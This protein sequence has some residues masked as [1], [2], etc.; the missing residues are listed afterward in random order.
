MSY[1]LLLADD[2]SAFRE[3]VREVCTPFFEILE[4]DTGDAAWEIAIVAQPDLALCDFHM[5]G[6]TGLE[7][8]S[9][10]K[11]IDVRRPAILMSSELSPDLEQLA[12]RAHIDSLLQKPFSRRILL[13]TF[14]A[15]METAYHDQSF[16]QRLLSS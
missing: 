3:I 9:A 5:P 1:R 12:Q 16:S 7:A 13:R 15:V 6:R 2:D 14:A 10:F 11:A 8:L 4:A